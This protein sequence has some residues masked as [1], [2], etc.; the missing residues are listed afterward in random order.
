[1]TLTI[2]AT[3]RLR[4]NDAVERLAKAAHHVVDHAAARAEA[5]GE[6]RDAWVRSVGQ[7]IRNRPLSSVMIAV[8]AGL[9]IGRLLR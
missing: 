6:K 2:P 9:V 8:V 5:L 1:M 4:A 3:E 7:P